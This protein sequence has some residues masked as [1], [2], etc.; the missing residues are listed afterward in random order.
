MF[1]RK[2]SVLAF[3]VAAAFSA[4]AQQD[5]ETS[6][7][8]LLGPGDE[9]TVKALGEP[10]FDFVAT[11]DED[12]RVAV[13]FVDQPVMAKCKTER[14]LGSE[15]ATLWKKYLRSPQVHLRV[16]QRNSRPPVSIWGE[17]RQQSQ[18]PLTRRAFLLELISHAG[19]ETEKAGGMVQ[20]FRTRPPLCA[21]PGSAEWGPTTADGLNVP[22]RMYSLAA[23]RQGREESNPEIF[24]GD[25]IIV[26]KAAPV[27]VTGEVIKPGEI[28]IP[29]GGLPLMQAVAMAS[30][31][32]RDAK[33]KEIK[34]YRRKAGTTQP[35]VI[36]ANYDLIRKGEQKDVM[37]QPLDIVEVGK[38]RKGIG[39]IF[40][41]VLTGLPNRI[42]IRPL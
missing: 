17:V 15:I 16:T 35:E 41:E 23:L 31:I 26:P 6:K 38:S 19:G 3:L 14:Q 37:L 4:A 11:I 25:I 29:E 13:P 36:A 18:V 7:G 10:Q 22:Y 40:M 20:V 33:T 30:G 21:E 24:P 42:P 8:Y 34:I 9:V 28:N 1:T 12:G 5:T 27:Y 32:T 39:E 2:L